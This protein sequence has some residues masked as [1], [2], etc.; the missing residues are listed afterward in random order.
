MAAKAVKVVEASKTNT[1]KKEQKQKVDVVRQCSTQQAKQQIRSKQQIAT[2][3]ESIS[4]I[5][6][7]NKELECIGFKLNWMNL[8]D[9]ENGKILWQSTEDLANPSFEH[10]AK[11]PKNILK[12]KS[13]SREINF[14]S[15]RKFEKF[16]LE[17]RVFLNN[18]PI[19]EWY[20]DFGF[21]IPQST[22]TWQTL[23]EA[24]PEGQMLPASILSGNIVI[25]TSFFDDDFLVSTS[26]VRLYYE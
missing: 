9:A 21:V 16:R 25:E 18:R 11:I 26:R 22:N 14:T 15:E 6:N 23:I 12:C 13:V 8:R 2:S 7:N 24:A 1:V 17:Q 3:S 4:V 19:E 10:K 20:F 5:E